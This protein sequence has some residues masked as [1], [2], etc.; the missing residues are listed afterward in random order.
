MKLMLIQIM[1][2]GTLTKLENI[3]YNNNK[4]NA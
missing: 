3:E 1:T 4:G 2:A